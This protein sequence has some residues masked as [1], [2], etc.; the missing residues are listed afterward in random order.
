METVLSDAERNLLR[1]AG[2]SMEGAVALYGRQYGGP[3]GVRNEVEAIKE[4][5]EAAIARCVERAERPTGSLRKAMAGTAGLEALPN[6]KEWEP[7]ALAE[8]GVREHRETLAHGRASRNG[9][10]RV[11]EPPARI[12]AAG[13]APVPVSAGPPPGS[14]PA[15]GDHRARVAAPSKFER[16]GR[17]PARRLSPAQV[18]AARLDGEALALLYRQRMTPKRIAAELG[19]AASTAKDI[20]VRLVDRGEA[21]RTGEGAF[22]W[23]GASRHG[24]PG[25]A[26][27][28]AVEPDGVLPVAREHLSA[29]REVKVTKA[30]GQTERTPDEIARMY[31]ERWTPEVRM[32]VA[33][34]ALA[35]TAE[36]LAASN[37]S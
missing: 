25:V 10:G 6:S 35:F 19:V 31:W 5:V 13:A 9:N 15:T 20:G 18:T 8:Q 17:K 33:R 37:P 12:G 30:P 7:A 24:R 4:R 14:A 28:L 27:R 11:S 2:R 1:M 21:V 26:L 23:P 29:G 16:S 34:L 22:D 3:A 32:A 36:Q